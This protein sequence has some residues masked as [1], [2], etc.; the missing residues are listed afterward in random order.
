MSSHRLWNS[1]AVLANAERATQLGSLWTRAFQAWVW[2]LKW[3]RKVPWVTATLYP[4]LSSFL[5]HF[6]KQK[7]MGRSFEAAAGQEHFTWNHLQPSVKWISCQV[8]S[9]QSS[10]VYWWKRRFGIWIILICFYY[11]VNLSSHVIE[12]FCKHLDTLYLFFIKMPTSWLSKTVI[13]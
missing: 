4:S 11:C 13:S 1:S 5:E 10:Q 8:L 3:Q 6:Q 7:V 12:L 9:G 2:P